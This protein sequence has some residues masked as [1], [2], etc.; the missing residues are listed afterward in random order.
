[1]IDNLLALL[2]L[3]EGYRQFPYRDTVGKLTIGIGFNLDDTGLFE[4][5]ARAVLALRIGRTARQLTPHLTWLV[6]LDPVRQAVLLDMA[7]NLGVPGLLKF[8]NTLAHVQAGRYKAAA[9]NML[10]SKWA[11][12]VG[13]RATRLA[14]MM[15]TGQWPQGN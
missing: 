4:D 12:Q 8:K 14:A 1:V 10:L 9:A 3:H 2:T 5:E 6:N 11:A 15:E 7:F 13:P